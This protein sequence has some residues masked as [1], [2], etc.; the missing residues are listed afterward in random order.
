M[1]VNFTHW[2]SRKVVRQYQWVA[3][4]IKNNPETSL[5]KKTIKPVTAQTFFNF[6]H[7]VKHSANIIKIS[8]SFFFEHHHTLDIKRL[9]NPD[10]K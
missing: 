1:A 4:I 6:I 5:F 10:W 7:P 3:V 2:C 8:K 9:S